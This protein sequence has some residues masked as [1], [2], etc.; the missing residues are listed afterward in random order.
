MEKRARRFTGDLHRFNGDCRAVLVREDGYT[1]KYLSWR[2]DRCRVDAAD[3]K[4][5]WRA[6]DTDDGVVD[7]RFEGID[8]LGVRGDADTEVDAATEERLK[9]LGYM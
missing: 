6:A 3:A 4:A 7:D 2:E 9:Q 8:D 1:R 5:S